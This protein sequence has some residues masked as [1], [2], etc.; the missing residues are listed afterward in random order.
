MGALEAKLDDLQL[1]MD[2]HCQIEAKC[3][4]NDYIDCRI[5]PNFFEIHIK[6]FFN[7][8]QPLKIQQFQHNSFFNLLNV[9]LKGIT[10]PVSA[11]R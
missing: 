2:A 11:K 4:G 1:K 8:F 7:H 3:C 6:V 9:F 10:L 5:V